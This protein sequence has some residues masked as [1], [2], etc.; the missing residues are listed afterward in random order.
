MYP[1]QEETHV[2]LALNLAQRS[3]HRAME[4]A[5]KENGLPS[6]RWYD[7]LWELERAKE[8]LRPF[9]LERRLI[10]E[11]S[12]LSHMLRRIIGEGLVE[13]LAHKGDGRGKVVRI[14]A[15]GR[16]VRKRMW[17]VYGPLIHQHFSKIPDE[18][19]HKDITSA[20]NSLVV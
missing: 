2:W 15:A 6:L 4:A 3:I 1:T 7:V 13:Q 11:Q 20:L 16:K 12:N 18:H 17:K 19:K 14:T 10:F 5:L 8:G 9:E